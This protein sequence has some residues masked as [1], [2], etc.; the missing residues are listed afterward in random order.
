MKT[1]DKTWSR[2]PRILRSGLR[3]LAR[4]PQADVQRR[5]I[6]QILRSD[7]LQAKLTIGE[8]NDKYEQ[9]ADRVADQVMSMPEPGLQRQEMP[10]EEEEAVQAKALAEGGTPLLQRQAEPNE[11][12]L[13]ET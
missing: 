5:Q 10:E 3:G 13:E 8:P 12:E 7:M 2:R 11:E 6:G 9:E 4:K 1:R